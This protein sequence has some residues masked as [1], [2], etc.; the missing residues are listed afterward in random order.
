LFFLIA[1]LV[2]VLFPVTIFENIRVLFVRVP[3][4]E[5]LDIMGQTLIALGH[6]HLHFCV[7]RDLKPE[8]L[9]MTSDGT[10]KLCDFGFARVLSKTCR[11]LRNF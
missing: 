4:Q 11:S 10:V 1:E 8:N 9:L 2:I 5:T 6:C 7:H 3:R